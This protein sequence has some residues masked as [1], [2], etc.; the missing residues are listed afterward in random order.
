MFF[1]PSLASSLP[2]LSPALT[3]QPKEAK[4]TNE[5]VHYMYNVHVY[6]C[7]RAHTDRHMY[8]YTP[9]DAPPPLLSL[10]SFYPLLPSVVVPVHTQ[11]SLSFLVIL[12]NTNHFL[13]QCLLLLQIFLHFSLSLFLLSLLILKPLYPRITGVGIVYKK[14]KNGRE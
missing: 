8:T 10:S 4:T 12:T 2:F 3:G 1:S 9:S 5:Q 7:M 6:T 13:L 14:E 11:I